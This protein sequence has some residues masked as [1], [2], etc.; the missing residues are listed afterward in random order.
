[1]KNHRAARSLLLFVLLLLALL[2][3]SA[4]LSLAQAPP[5]NHPL[6]VQSGGTTTRVSVASDGT[7]G[8]NSSYMGSL[9]ADGRYVAFC[10]SFPLDRDQAFEFRAR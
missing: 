8:N 6:S 7:Q 10:G 4:G 1:M 5:A 2:P 3:G 9:S